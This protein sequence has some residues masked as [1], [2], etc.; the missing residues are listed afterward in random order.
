MN[1]PINPIYAMNWGRYIGGA[2][3]GMTAGAIYGNQ[4]KSLSTRMTLGGLFGGAYPAFGGSKEQSGHG[5]LGRLGLGIGITVGGSAAGM[6]VGYG[7]ARLASR[8]RR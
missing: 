3:G 2:A 8:F 1:H 5:F 7:V 4:D 6:G